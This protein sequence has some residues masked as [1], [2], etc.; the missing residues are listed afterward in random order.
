M[1]E[2]GA[3]GGWL[4]SCRESA[5]LSQE[6]LAER[7]GLS[8]RALRNLEGGRTSRP[9]PDSIRRLADAL[10]LRGEARA[11]FF[12]AAGRRLAGNASAG[13]AAAPDGGLARAGS[14]RV[15]PR[16]NWPR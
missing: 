14:E 5:G 2:A 15:V 7:A 9:Y 10:V 1:T 6:K 16:P 3:F 13:A 11:E 8:V 12:A 4:R